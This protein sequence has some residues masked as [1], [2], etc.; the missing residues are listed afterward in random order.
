MSNF[1][2]WEINKQIDDVLNK[3][4]I[5]AEE[6]DGEVSEETTDLLA[7]LKMAQF[8][9]IE[10]IGCK[11]KNLDAEIEALDKEEKAIEDRKNS[12]KKSRERLAN[13]ASAMLGGEK[14]ESSKVVFS[15][16]KSK[17]TIVDDASKIPDEFFKVTVERKANL[18]S[19]K[20]AIEDGTIKE[21]A[22]IEDNVTMNI[23]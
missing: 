3:M 8:D 18:K 13:Y 4:F 2:L 19:I 15:F 21:G 22:H 20:K 14:W 5:E 6:N 16:R 17:K 11:L 23:K 10:A 7:E 1:T 9:K 12:K